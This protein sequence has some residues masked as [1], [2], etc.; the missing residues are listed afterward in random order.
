MYRVAAGHDIAPRTSKAAAALE[1]PVDFGGGIPDGFEMIDLPSHLYMWY[2]AAPYE[3]ENWCGMAHQ[4]LYR[5]IG[6]YKPELYGYEYAMDDA[7][8]FNY[9]APA[10]TGVRQMIPIRK[11]LVK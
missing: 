7:P 6:N 2:N 8:V 3:D 5:A 9:F 11:L 10:I 1:V 4:E